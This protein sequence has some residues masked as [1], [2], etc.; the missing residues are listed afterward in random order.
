MN[1][2]LAFFSIIL[3]IACLYVLFFW[4][5]AVDSD[6]QL[7]PQHSQP[8]GGGFSLQTLSGPASLKDYRGKVVLLYFGYT[9]CPDVCPTNLAMMSNALMQMDD[10]ELSRVQGIFISVDPQRDT[11]ERL[12]E[13]TKYF[14]QSL[15]GMTST[16]EVI[17]ELADRYGVAYQKVVQES[18]ANY[19]VDHSSETYVVDPQ[20]NLVERLPHAAPPADI[21]AAL[22]KYSVN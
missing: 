2:A 15:I 22:R 10:D 20:G 11:L 12:S 9:M 6:H 3:S 18:A 16:P 8:T 19:A 21:L 7:L 1:K 4:Q 17:R 13:Y 5:P 14:H